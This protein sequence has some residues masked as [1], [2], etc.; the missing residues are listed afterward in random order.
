M[1]TILALKVNGQ[2]VEPQ[3]AGHLRDNSGIGARE[4]F[5]LTPD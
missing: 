5:K 1:H 2:K 3:S 4:G